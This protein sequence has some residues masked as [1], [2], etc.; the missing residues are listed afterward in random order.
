MYATGECI[1]RILLTGGSGD[2]GSILLPS[3]ATTHDVI[4]V[5]IQ[6]RE[7]DTNKFVQGSILDRELLDRTFKQIDYIVHIAAWHGIHQVRN[8]KSAFDFWDLNVT[9][10]FNVFETA[11]RNHVKGIVNISSTSVDEWPDLYGAS[12]VLN[13]EIARTYA[14][15]HALPVITLRP[16]AFIPYWNKT[17]YKNYIEWAQWYWKGAVHI[18]D[19]A[20]AVIKSLDLL[21]S[22]SD[23]PDNLTLVV[24]G[25]YEYTLN[26]LARWDEKGPGST[27]KRHYPE[28][29]ALVADHGLDPGVKP[30][31][32]DMETTISWLG[33]TPR[34]SL[35]NLLEELAQFGEAGPPI[36]H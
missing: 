7:A 31:I 32:L 35:Q 13:E 24:D 33:Y 5:D 14:A 22:R 19:V 2:L 25:A 27:F 20:Q 30:S 10:T 11:V 17:V 29:V 23:L 6:S 8:E 34:Y 21:I 16:R 3:L 18:D 1:L 36:P 4:N 26:D 9:G 28:H 15:R 12:K